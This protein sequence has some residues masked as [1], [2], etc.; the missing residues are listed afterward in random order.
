MSP[1]PAVTLVRTDALAPAPY[2]HAAVTGQGRLVFTAG[3]CPL[4]V[5]VLG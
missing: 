5:T 2:A 4:G 3:A 1:D